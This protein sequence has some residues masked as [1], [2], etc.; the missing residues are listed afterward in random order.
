[1]KIRKS[2]AT[3]VLTSLLLLSLAQVPVMSYAEGTEGLS[4]GSSES[5]SVEQDVLPTD[6]MM[7][8]DSG[9]ER[10]TPM[11]A[12]DADE[13]GELADQDGVEL[14][15]SVGAITV[16]LEPAGDASTDSRN[17]Q[18]ALNKVLSTN[19]RV[20]VVLRGGTFSINRIL[21]IYSNTE[22]GLDGATV[23]R[24]NGCS[25]SPML[26]TVEDKDATNRVGTTGPRTSPSPEGRGT[27]RRT[28]A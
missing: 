27:A 12:D 16:E 28:R 26:M 15:A 21:R 4:G 11:A 1:M 25:N 23:L 24:A 13:M 8:E 18:N 20:L 10:L 3:F 14:A 7:P 5:V 2:S 9:E 6:G 19:E 22:L 17:I